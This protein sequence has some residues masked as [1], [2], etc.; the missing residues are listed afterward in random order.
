[1]PFGARALLAMPA[2]QV[3]LIRFA[4][5]GIAVYAMGYSTLR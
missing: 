4:L 2:G 3:G 1:M 5:G